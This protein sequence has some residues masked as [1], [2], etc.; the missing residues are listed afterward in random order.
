MEAA[1]RGLREAQQ[2]MASVEE[3]LSAYDTLRQELPGRIAG[4]RAAAVE[5]SGLLTARQSEGYRTSDNDPAPGAAEQAAEAV[6]GLSAEQR[7]GD[8]A[9]A[10]VRAEADLAGHRAWL[11][12]LAAFRAALI[13]DTTR[14]RARATELDTAIADAYV[15]TEGLERDQDPSCVEGVRSTADRAAAARKSLDGALRTIETH[16]SMADQQFAR[17]REELTAAQQSAE[18]IATDAAVPALRVEQLRA[19]SVDLPMRAERAV[20][21]AEAVQGQVTTHPAAMTFLAEVPDVSVLRAGA[22]GVGAD[23]ALPKPPYLRLDEQLAEVEAGLTRA[24]A[25]VDGGIADHEASQRALENAASAVAAA[26]GEVSQSDVS[27][28]ARQMLEEAQ[29]LLAQAEAETGSLAAITSGAD[30]AKDRANAAS[31]RARQDRRD[32]EQRREAARR[33][34]ASAAASRRR[35]SGGG[36]SFSSR[37]GSSRSG[38]GGS[39]SFGGGGGSRRSG[40]GG[41]RGF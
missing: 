28:A 7:F 20:V 36:S 5:V 27:G 21:E 19:L 16:T 11:T 24:R 34:A 40:G 17:A 38:G 12:E 35:S 4:L 14:L 3:R 37:G 25:V 26:R 2:A 31:A 39:R 30:A 32:A 9:A 13:E 22:E 18:A 10:L 23:V 15:T 29:S 1:T 41:S 33:A 8:A 6:E